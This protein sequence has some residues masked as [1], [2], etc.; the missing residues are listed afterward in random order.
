MLPSGYQGLVLQ[1]IAADDVGVTR[2]EFF[3]PG[4][5]TPFAVS[6]PQGGAPTIYTGSSP[7]TTLP[8]VTEDTLVTFRARAYDASNNY[9]DATTTVKV[10]ANTTDLSA[11]GSNDWTALAGKIAVLRG[12]VLTVDV[13]RTLGGLIVLRGAA[14]THSASATSAEK[15]LSLTI[16][17]P[18]YVECGGLVDANGKGYRGDQ[19]YPGETKSGASAGGTHIG[20]GSGNQPPGSSYGSITRP[21]ENG[22]GG[23]GT[24]GAPGGGVVRMVSSDTFIVDGIVRANGGNGSGSAPSG[25]G[26]SIWLIR[27]KVYSCSSR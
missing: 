13:P 14:I 1:A 12:G 25:A 19:T 6:T 26:G 5:T 27:R 23:G 10:V 9:T 18:V 3:R 2:I 24:V 16:N 7:G 17:G 11:T 15:S 22:A 8:A 4:D 21:S 20:L